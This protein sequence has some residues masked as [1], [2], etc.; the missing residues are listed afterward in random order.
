M[1]VVRTAELVSKEANLFQFELGSQ[2]SYTALL[3]VK[4]RMLKWMVT[5]R[6]GEEEEEEGLGQGGNHHCNKIY[7]IKR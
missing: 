4:A 6:E 3:G 2:L 5:G 1:T 7:T